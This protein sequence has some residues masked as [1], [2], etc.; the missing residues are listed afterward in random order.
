MSK[1]YIGHEAAGDYDQTSMRRTPYFNHSWMARLGSQ[2]EYQPTTYCCDNDEISLAIMG[3]NRQISRESA[4]VFYGN[5]RFFFG[6]SEMIL[7]FL[8]DRNSQ[9]LNWI[10]T[11]SMP[12]PS[13]YGLKEC[14]NHT[15][16][17]SAYIRLADDERLWEES[18]EAIGMFLPNLRRLDLRVGRS[19]SALVDVDS[20]EDEMDDKHYS[21]IQKQSFKD[22]PRKRRQELATL[23]Q[24]VQIVTSAE[25]NWPVV[26]SICVHQRNWYFQPLRPALKTKIAKAC[27]SALR[28]APKGSDARMVALRDFWQT[29]H[30]RPK[31]PGFIVPNGNDDGL[32]E[33]NN[34]GWTDD[35]SGGEDDFLCA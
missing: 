26:D 35:S 12:Y 1:I 33:S 23:G 29:R 11:I 7:P 13:P 6:A 24:E 14:A 2:W 5:N 28:S 15:Y 18:C 22:F 21:E 9:A 4:E 8:K 10:L 31:H 34:D 3:T 16:G 20:D 27:P 30:V 19:F 17:Q 32:Q 25:T